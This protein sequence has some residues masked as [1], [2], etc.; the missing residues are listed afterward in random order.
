MVRR[1]REGGAVLSLFAV[2]GYAW[3]G[4][5]IAHEGPRRCSFVRIDGFDVLVG[6]P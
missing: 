1:R 3:C 2:R 5:R 4:V 6:S